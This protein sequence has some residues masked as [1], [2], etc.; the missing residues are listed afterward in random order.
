MMIWTTL[1]STKPPIELTRQ[2]RYRTTPRFENG[3]DNSF[4]L[5]IP[6]FRSRSP[7]S[8]PRRDSTQ[9]DDLTTLLTN[10]TEQTPTVISVEQT[11]A[12][13]TSSTIHTLI[14][15]PS[16]ASAESPVGLPAGSPVGSA[17]VT[18]KAQ[19]G[20]AGR[21]KG[22]TKPALTANPKFFKRMRSEKALSTKRIW[23]NNNM[24]TLTDER[25]V[26]F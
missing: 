24:Q 10:F 3:L 2:W 16:R 4:N 22:T 18:P 11:D 8:T 23:L 19:R 1:S 17:I 7:R 9:I 20:K 5:T 25:L 14:S 12:D 6:N 26:S 21:P 15:S 13:R